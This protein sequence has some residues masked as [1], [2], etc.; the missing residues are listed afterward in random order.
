MNEKVMEMY[1]YLTNS[2]L[3]YKAALE[4]MKER[5]DY[6][7]PPVHTTGLKW[8]DYKDKLNKWIEV[9]LPSIYRKVWDSMTFHDKTVFH[10]EVFSRYSLEVFGIHLR[11]DNH[12]GGLR[13]FLKNKVESVIP[14]SICSGN[15]EAEPVEW[16]EYVFWE[17]YGVHK[18]GN[19]FTGRGE[20]QPGDRIVYPG[21]ELIP[22]NYVRRL[23]K[24]SKLERKPDWIK[25]VIKAMA[26]GAGRDAL[27]K[28]ATEIQPPMLVRPFKTDRDWPHSPFHVTP[29]SELRGEF[30][31]TKPKKENFMLKIEDTIFINSTPSTGY[32]EDQLIQL[33]RD[34][35]TEITKLEDIDTDSS[36]IEARLKSLKT[37]LK[38]LAEI[39]D[40]K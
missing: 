7:T 24:L 17:D 34:T 28:I 29:K 36:K 15:T 6:L 4:L 31:K 10:R 13:A 5:G 3:F 26:Y 32:T 8:G 19:I 18:R 20:K 1:N 39:L 35:E 11:S 25:R 40:A 37:D 22:S 30:I 9:Y 21:P 16:H 14:E 33:I 12:S 27:E 2:K 23:D 38:R